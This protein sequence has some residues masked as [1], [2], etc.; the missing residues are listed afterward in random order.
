MYRILF[1]N[2]YKKLVMVAASGKEDSVASGKDC[3]GDLFSLVIFGYIIN[4]NHVSTSPNHMHAKKQNKRTAHSKL[5]VHTPFDSVVSL[6]IIIP[7]KY[8]QMYEM[9]YFQAH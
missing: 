9:M 4:M 2:I 3:E 7:S 6:L 1:G 5:Q 8:I